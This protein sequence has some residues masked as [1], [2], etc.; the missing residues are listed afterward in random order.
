MRTPLK[1]YAFPLGTVLIWS[2]NTIAC[3][4]AVGLIE[5]AAI[6]FYRWLIAG[7]LIAPFAGRA[8]WRQRREI[9]P[10]LP[11][12]FV[13]G[14]LG[15]VLYQVLCYLASATTSATNMGIMAS[16]MPLMTVV[17]SVFLLGERPSVGSIAGGV[18]ALFGLCFLLSQGHPADL[19]TL[20]IGLGDGLMLLGCVIYAAYGVLLKRW[21]LPFDG[22]TGLFMQ[23]WCA[24]VLLFV[25]YLAESAPPLTFAGLP[26]VLFAAI[27]TSILSPF[28]WMYG[29]KLLGPTRCISW[30]NLMPLFTVAMAMPMIGETLQVY[31]YVGGGMALAGVLLAQCGHIPLLCGKLCCRVAEAREA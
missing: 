1:Y 30:M 8:V 27:P 29:V 22:W 17:L 4:M 23:I 26:M 19:L 12:F 2:A 21:S 3:K 11:K 14:A 31:H 24:I 20:G 28:L 25:Y 13:L 6:A 16:L 7:V 9:I 15:M 18:L 5:P 10:Y